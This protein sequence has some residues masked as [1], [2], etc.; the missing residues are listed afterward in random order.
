M[1]TLSKKELMNKALSTITINIGKSGVNKNVF[2]EI[3]RQLKANEIVKLRF[4]KGVSDEK[5]SHINNIVVNTKSK[6]VDLRGN[7]AIIYKRSNN[8]N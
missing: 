2:E 8:T 3:K 6:L 7:V 4:A 5:E 1:L